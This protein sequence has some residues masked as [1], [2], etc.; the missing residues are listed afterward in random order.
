MT[1][2][3]M[4]ITIS[5]VIFCGLLYTIYLIHSTAKNKATHKVYK[6]RLS[7]KSRLPR[8]VYDTYKFTKTDIQ[9][10][11]EQY[12]SVYLPRKHSN[13]GEYSLPDFKD[14]LNLHFN[15]NKSTTAYTML[16]KNILL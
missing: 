14:D 5:A 8:K 4:V 2:E 9:Y 16:C 11:R 10:I 15:I 12:I 3:L 1:K 7:R 6:K 13:N